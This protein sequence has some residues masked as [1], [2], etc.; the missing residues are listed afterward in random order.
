MEVGNDQEEEEDDVSDELVEVGND[1]EEE[2]DDVSRNPS[3]S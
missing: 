2:E 3:S 1:E